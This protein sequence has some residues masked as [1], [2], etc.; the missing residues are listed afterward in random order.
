MSIVSFVLV[1]LFSVSVASAQVIQGSYLLLMD[2]SRQAQVEHL[3]SKSEIQLQKIPGSTKSYTLKFFKNDPGLKMLSESKLFESVESD[4]FMPAAKLERKLFSVPPKI[5]SDG[6]VPADPSD[7]ILPND[8][9]FNKCWALHNAKGGPD[10]GAARA[11]KIRT[12]TAPDFIIAV[13]DSGIDLKHPDLKDNLWVNPGEIAG[14]GIDD[15]KNG[16]IDDVHGVNTWTGTGNPQDEVGHGTLVAGI[17]GAVG[18]NSIGT[19]GVIWKTKIMAINGNDDANRMSYSGAVKGGYYA[20]ANG[21]KV[22]NGSWGTFTACPTI[23]QMILDLNDKGILFV[24]AVGNVDNNI[25][26]QYLEYP[27]AYRIPNM[28]EVTAVDKDNEL[29]PRAN[30]G[31]KYVQ[32]AAPGWLIHTTALGL[33]YTEDYGT[34]LA[35][36]FVTAAVAMVWSEFPSLTYLEVKAKILSSVD[37]VPSLSDKVATSGRL[38]LEKALSPQ[39]KIL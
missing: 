17:I 26:T 29:T 13:I 8:P 22:V 1:S 9:D 27:A 7:V 38:N 20:A 35:A 6:S 10:M 14:N 2:S 19:T 39:T 12:E 28:I 32:L 4:Y 15:D 11:W 31:K 30:F 36:P 18:N 16:Y 37:V 24:G 34:S 25:D 5:M 23:Q 21:A 33:K 3:F